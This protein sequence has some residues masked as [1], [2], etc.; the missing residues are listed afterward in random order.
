[1]SGIT[2]IVAMDKN[3]V[4]GKN[5]DIPWSGRLRGDMR[6]FKIYTMG[7]TVVMGRKT[8]DSIPEK[9]KPLVGRNNLVLTR[10]KVWSSHG[11]T[12]VHDIEEIFAIS[13]TEE[14]CVMGGAEIYRLFLPFANK[15]ILTIVN[16]CVENGDTFFPDI[17]SGWN[18]RV[19]SEQKA[20]DRNQHSFTIFEFTR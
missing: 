16:T 3:N 8:Y 1:M 6:H 20:D 15:I 13:A 12:V 7:K 17:E 14:I 2:M 10:D 18:R 9:F 11:C 19:L 4:I 5:G